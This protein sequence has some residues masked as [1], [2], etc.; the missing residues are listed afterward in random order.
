VN[1]QS[2][3]TGVDLSKHNTVA[4]SSLASSDTIQK[5]VSGATVGAISR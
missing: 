5:S 4:M 2:N 3:R 1:D